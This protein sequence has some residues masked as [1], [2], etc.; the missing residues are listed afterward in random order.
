[1]R[2]FL[3]VFVAAL[4][5]WTGPVD[6]QPWVTETLQEFD[7]E[8]I[9][10]IVETEIYEAIGSEAPPLALWL[11]DG[12]GSETLQK[13]AGKT[14][15]IQFWTTDC[16]PCIAQ[17]TDLG[18]LQVAFADRGVQMIYV[19]PERPE[20]LQRFLADR[21]IAGHYRIVDEQKLSPPYQVIAKPTAFVIGPEGKIQNGWLG[22][23]EPE[24][25]KELIATH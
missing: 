25:L 16:P 19:S 4:L 7:A 23:E 5:L 22:A 8:R 21:E 3:Y 13:Y 24:T 11:L 2:H 18:N 12:T 17:M 20:T 9:T 14:V 10:D 1:M 15:V 6:A